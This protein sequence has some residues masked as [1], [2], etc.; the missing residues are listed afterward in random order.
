MDWAGGEAG[1][2][3]LHGTFITFVNGLKQLEVPYLDGYKHGVETH[4][5]DGK[6]PSKQVSWYYNRKHGPTKYFVNGAVV[7][8]EYYDQG[9]QVS[10]STWNELARIE[11]HAMRMAEENLF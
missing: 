9:K 4:Y 11:D 7:S 6:S 2:T 5:I 1:S 3:E 8:A 10:E